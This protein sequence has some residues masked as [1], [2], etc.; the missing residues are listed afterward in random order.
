MEKYKIILAR[1]IDG[2][3]LRHFEFLMRVSLPAAKRFRD[4]FAE[5]LHEIGMNPLQFPV[6]EDLN[7]P[8]GMYRKAIFAKRYKILFL[9]DEDI[10]FIDAVVDC[11]QNI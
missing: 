4:A 9:I 1:R 5:T 10:V 2:Q 8:S 7:L 3:L 11:R 6:E